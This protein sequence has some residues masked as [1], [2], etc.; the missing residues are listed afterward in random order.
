MRTAAFNAKKG[1]VLV[2]LYECSVPLLLR[3]VDD[4]FTFVGECY[5]QGLMDGEATKMSGGHECKVRDFG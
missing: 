4:Y 5:V 1:D 3:K 2:V